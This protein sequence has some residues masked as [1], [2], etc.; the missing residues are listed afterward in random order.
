MLGSGLTMAIIH[1]QA[2]VFAGSCVCV[3][4]HLFQIEGMDEDVQRE[5]ILPQDAHQA[6]FDARQRPRQWPREP[7]KAHGYPLAFGF[8]SATPMLKSWALVNREAAKDQ[9]SREPEQDDPAARQG[10]PRHC[11]TIPPDPASFGHLL[12]AVAAHFFTGPRHT[13]SCH[14]LWRLALAPSLA[15]TSRNG[16]NSSEVYQERLTR[17]WCGPE[18]TQTKLHRQRLIGKRPRSSVATFG[19]DVSRCEIFITPRRVVDMTNIQEEG[20]HKASEENPNKHSQMTN[21]NSNFDAESV[22]PVFPLLLTAHPRAS[23]LRFAVSR[24]TPSTVCS[25]INC[26]CFPSASSLVGGKCLATPP[27]SV[28]ASPMTDEGKR[29]AKLLLWWCDSPKSTPYIE[30]SIG[31]N[32]INQNA[33]CVNRRRTLADFRPSLGESLPT[34]GIAECFCTE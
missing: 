11:G 26:I 1:L 17:V 9:E 23:V 24:T 27:P 4:T 10:A 12:A 28:T 6:P 3:C 22:R 18:L 14:P 30:V 15:P 19:A 21:T 33:P 13:S 16:G 2:K 20:G 29:S 25:K 34:M 8:F 32:S 5:I 31:L 7:I